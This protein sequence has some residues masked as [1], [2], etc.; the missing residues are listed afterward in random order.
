MARQLEGQWPEIKRSAGNEDEF[1]RTT[2]LAT[3]VGCLEVGLAALGIQRQG[4]EGVQERLRRARFADF[5]GAPDATHLKDA[6]EARNRS[7]HDHTVADINEC[8]EHIGT[9]YKA[10]CALR[11]AF[12]TKS[13]A[14]ALAKAILET[15]LVSDVFLFGSLVVPY[16]GRDPKD[17]DLLLFDDGE[18]SSRIILYDGPEAVL[19]EGFLTTPATQAAIRCGWLDYIFVDGTR[20]GTDRKYTLSLAQSQP[21]PLFFVNISASLRAFERRT[22]QWTDTR[23]QMFSRLAALRTQLEIENIVP[24]ADARE[25]SARQRTRR[26]TT[27]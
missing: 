16:R 24:S 15:G 5:K 20:F 7:V 10:W 21:D 14:A 26:L 25:R 22:S 4:R 12:V 13:N 1:H 6:I 17:I 3:A 27:W 23:P 8:R 11:R 9:L 19:E 18:Y 2:A